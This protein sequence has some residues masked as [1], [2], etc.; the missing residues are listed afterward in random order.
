MSGLDIAADGIDKSNQNKEL[1]TLHDNWGIKLHYEP[2]FL[3]VQ[4]KLYGKYKSFCEL[5]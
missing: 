5:D 2:I 3:V 1:R 4:I